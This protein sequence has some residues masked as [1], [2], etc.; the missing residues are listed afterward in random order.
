[1]IAKLE[2]SRA[3]RESGME[4]EQAKAI[5]KGRFCSRESIALYLSAKADSAT[6]LSVVVGKSEAIRSSL[7]MWMIGLVI[8]VSRSPSPS[9]ASFVR[10]EESQA[11]RSPESIAPSTPL[12]LTSINVPG[13]TSSFAARRTGAKCRVRPLPPRSTSISRTLP[14]SAA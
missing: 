6:A 1:M 9:P 7:I 11:A 12:I 2:T 10:A 13:G 8:A 5:A 4:E 14:C 3:S